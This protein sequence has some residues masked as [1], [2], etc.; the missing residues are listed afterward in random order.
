MN[1]IPGVSQFHIRRTQGTDHA[2]QTVQQSAGNSFRDHLTAISTTDLRESLSVD[3]R[4]ML[5]D[6]FGQDEGPHHPAMV[7]NHALRV[8]REPLIPK[9]S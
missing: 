1:Q 2:R 4:R 9:K 3:E 7:R 8:I 6:L 5:E